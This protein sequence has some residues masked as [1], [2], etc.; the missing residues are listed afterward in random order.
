MSAREGGMRRLQPG[1]AEIGR[2]EVPI[3]EAGIKPGLAPLPDAGW[4][5]G[6]HWAYACLVSA[7][8]GHSRAAGMA[9]PATTGF[10]PL[11]SVQGV[12]HPDS[13]GNSGLVPEFGLPARNHR[14]C[15]A[16]EIRGQRWPWMAAAIRTSRHQFFV[17]RDP[18][19][20]GRQVWPGPAAN[21][22]VSAHCRPPR[23]RSRRE[24]P[25]D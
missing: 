6:T 20:S 19:A 23:K 9:N 12:G 21:R 16:S 3:M 5:S 25:A 13:C 24:V 1:G 18:R 22:M 2:P 11:V 4:T 10:A 17:S 14:P 7:F 8:G 15:F